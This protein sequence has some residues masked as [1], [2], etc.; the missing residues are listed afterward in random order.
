MY[1]IRSLATLFSTLQTFSL[2]S[3]PLQ[4]SYSPFIHSLLCLPFPLHQLLS[5]LALAVGSWQI[6]SPHHL[7]ISPRIHLSDFILHDSG[8]LF[9]ALDVAYRQK[10]CKELRIKRS[11]KPSSKPCKM[12]PLTMFIFQPAH[13]QSVC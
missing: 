2:L 3:C 7:P 8:A 11:T 5:T 12:R 13:F 9:G 1:N 6:A 10:Y 4:F